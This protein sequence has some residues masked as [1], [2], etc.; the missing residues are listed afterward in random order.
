MMRLDTIIINVGYKTHRSRKELISFVLMIIF[1]MVFVISG[2][3]DGIVKNGKNGGKNLVDE[4][5]NFE[6][7]TQIRKI[8]IAIGEYGYMLFCVIVISFFNRA[9]L[10]ERIDFSELLY[11]RV[12]SIKETILECF[13]QSDFMYIF[14]L[15]T[16]ATDTDMENYEK[17]IATKSAIELLLK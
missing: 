14:G 15:E 11:L 7:N 17:K 8:A 13:C 12:F 16:D 3:V 4:S 5:Y 9:G 6:K 2:L 10:F 1:F